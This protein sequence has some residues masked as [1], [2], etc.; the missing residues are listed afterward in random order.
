MVDE[1]NISFL[2]S[3]EKVDFTNC[4]REPI[5][6]PN[7]IQPHGLLLILS[8]TDFRILGVSQ[9]TQSLLGIAAAALIERPLAEFVDRDTID[10]MIGCLQKQFENTNPLPITV[11]VE[12]SAATC[13]NGI[14]HRTPSKEVILELE[15][16]D[17][18]LKHDFF[19]FYRQVKD[20]LAKIQT[21]HSLSELCNLIVREV[22]TITG[23][24]RVM[25]YRFDPRG[26]GTVIA[27]EKEP[28]LTESFLGLHYPDT[29][30]PKQ[31]KYLYTLN[32]LR[33]IPDVNY[34][35]APILHGTGGHSDEPSGSLD[36][37]Y[38]LL[39]SVSPIHLEYLK[40]M[41]VTASMSISLLHNQQLWG[42]IAC[43]H[44]EPKFVPY[45][46]R[47]VCEF[48]G[49]LMSTEI[50][51]KEANEDLDYQLRLK[52][53]QRN[54][55]EQLTG[56]QGLVTELSVAPERLMNL[57][58]AK[59]VAVCEGDH[60]VLLGQ[61][62]EREDVLSLLPWLGDRFKR[63]VFHT[64]RLSSLYPPAA[65][66]Q[67][68][69]SGLLAMAI[70]KIQHR[71]ILWFR[72]EMIQTVTWA[73]N[74]NKPRH[75]ED[76]GSLT[77][78]PRKSFEA[79]QEIVQ[80][81]SAPW[82]SCELNSVVE[83]RQAIV[84]IVLRQ[85]DELA[86]VNLEL[87]R[88]NTELDSFAYIASHDLKEPL[89]GIHNYATFLLEDY[90]EILREDGAD[91]LNTL[92]RLTKR[93]E[94]LIES[95]LKFSRLG[96]QELQMRPIDLN[97]LLIEVSEVFQMNPQWEGCSIDISES[98]PLVLG[99]RVLLAEV[100]M[101]LISNGFKYNKQAHKRVEIGWE[102]PSHGENNFVTLSF[103]DNGIGIREKHLDSVFRIFKRLHAAD[104]Y[105]GGTGA[106][107]TIVKKIVER[108]G[109]AIAVQSVYGEG[110]TFRVSLPAPD[111]LPA[112][113]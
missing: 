74:P 44:C 101:N 27:E 5:H 111:P 82:L 87:E 71:Y 53:I 105:G 80:G 66:Y 34:T 39:R 107:L 3:T 62:P 16:M 84:D 20:T 64:N 65:N 35:P 91:K 76:D 30:I 11:T 19:H 59:G 50:G 83:L 102:Q 63:D 60:I 70:S 109:G 93:M 13:F 77:I 72:P 56:T 100:L 12:G 31:A 94:L 98:L 26:D 110:T 29:D 58:G 104:R 61:T 79:W 90:G 36:M 18:R 96:R 47:T 86:H 21:A 6:V 55:I 38:S 32:W 10:A 8:E 7:A 112:Q 15:P 103:R 41:G 22:K 45:E 89:R 40:N 46:I 81:Q 42:L 68:C 52:D 106:G 25:V 95:L 97:Q 78:F 99:D 88:S 23:F 92:V 113:G 108:H 28:A 75:I 14:L 51:T 67:D 54:L 37:S 9:N 73:G 4:D 1:E 57:T 24:D 49:Q 85:A 43:H 2:E 69:A 33:L 17:S 48:L